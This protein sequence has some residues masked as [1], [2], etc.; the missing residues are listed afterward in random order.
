[1][2]KFS[3]LKKRKTGN[4]G[5]QDSPELFSRKLTRIIHFATGELAFETTSAVFE[6]KVGFV[7]RGTELGL[8]LVGIAFI[9]I[10]I[11]GNIVRKYKKNEK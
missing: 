3:A 2:D 5:L 4:V 10:E 7:G 11:S 1:M 6:E 8:G 9:F